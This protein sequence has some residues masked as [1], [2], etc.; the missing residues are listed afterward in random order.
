MGRAG[1]RKVLAD[2][3]GPQGRPRPLSRAS[4]QPLPA[5]NGP[6]ELVRVVLG[7]VAL[8]RTGVTVPADPPQG[9]VFHQG[10]WQLSLPHSQATV[11]PGASGVLTPLPGP[12]PWPVWVPAAAGQ[13]S[14]CFAPAREGCPG[15][16]GGPAGHR[17]QRG[18]GAWHL[19]TC[20]LLSRGGRW[21]SPPRPRAPSLMRS[22]SSVCRA[23]FVSCLFLEAFISGLGR[24][25]QPSSPGQPPELFS[26]RWLFSYRGCVCVEGAPGV[27][28]D[29]FAP[30]SAAL[31][32]SKNTWL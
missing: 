28:P 27:T 18:P 17:E 4:P 22:H 10:F 20:F 15:G 30:R 11:Q 16:V 2:K 14:S 9:P 32:L 3:Q 1:A 6:C 19:G 7:G 29:P 31:F 5:W 12:Q 23:L 26:L 24:F 21:H 8:E 25:S 13:G